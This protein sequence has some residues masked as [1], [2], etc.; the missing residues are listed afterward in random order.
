MSSVK[1]EKKAGYAQLMVNGKPFTILGGEL[2][3][4]SAASIAY[5]EPLLDKMKAC[6][7][8]TVLLG[9]GWDQFEPREGEYNLAHAEA[10]I[11]ACRERDLKLIPLWFATMKNAISCYTPE[12][13]KTDLKRFPRAESTP[14]VRGWTVSPLGKNVLEADCRAFARLL[15]CIKQVDG[16]RDDPTVIMV[17]PENE[18]GIF[19]ARRDYSAMAEVVF[20]TAVPERLLQ[21]LDAKPDALHPEMRAIRERSGWRTEG[22]WSEVFG[23]DADEVFTAWHTALFV[24]KVAAAGR[25]E[26][27]LPMYANAWLPGG[28]GF[29]PGTYPSGG[30]IPKMFDI[31]HLAAPSLDLLAP[32]IYHTDFRDRCASFVVQGNPLF[33]PEAKSTKIAAAQ[34]LY[35]IG[36]HRALGYSPWAIDE[37]EP[38]HPLVE[39]YKK[40][41]GV[42]EFIQKHHPDAEMRGFLQEQDAERW[43]AKLGDY[44]FVCRTARPLKELEVP[45][46]A[47]LVHLG[48]DEYLSLG[49]SLILTF[50]GPSGSAAELIRA[51]LGECRDGEWRP[52]RPFGGDENAHGT[53]ILLSQS[54]FFRSPYGALSEAPAAEKMKADLDLVRFRIF[55]LGK[56]LK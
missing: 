50:S 28:P 12:W 44:R 47:I 53:G 20:R 39:T 46:S 32:D 31:W 54:Q 51:E 13:V 56:E 35:A 7:L 8:N 42:L 11:R 49:R 41:G 43:E 36:E 30:P 15:K 25:A 24:G 29:E 34:S 33:I 16:D 1:I 26:Y 4:N 18:T 23:K 5:L 2:H 55:D 14:G 10:M 40:L 22:D 45:G 21:G 37:M 9:L 17:Q 19:N 3:N 48:G 38:D 27:D 52:I 6:R